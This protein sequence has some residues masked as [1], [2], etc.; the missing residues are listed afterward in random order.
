MFMAD[1]VRLLRVMER[2]TVQEGGIWLLCSLFLMCP[3]LRGAD[4][5]GGFRKGKGARPQTK[6]GQTLFVLAAKRL[7]PR[8]TASSPSEVQTK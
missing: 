8:T 7:K 4:K 5:K 3:V 2:R 1:N 6:K